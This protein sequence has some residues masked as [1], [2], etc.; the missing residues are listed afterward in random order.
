MKGRILLVD[1]FE[2]ATWDLAEQLAER[3]HEVLTAGTRVAALRILRRFDCQVAVVDADLA[4]GDGITLLGALRAERPQLAI[5]FT[6][7]RGGESLREE[8]RRRG[9]FSLVEKPYGTDAMATE[10]ERALAEGAA[11]TAQQQASG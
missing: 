3:G 5:V 2:H 4:D 9:A 1:P 11:P 6:A 8:A 7:A 10:V